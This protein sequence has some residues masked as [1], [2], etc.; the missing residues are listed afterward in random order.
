MGRSHKGF[1]RESAHEVPYQVLEM[2]YADKDNPHDL[3]KTSC[4]YIYT[5][6]SINEDQTEIKVN[7]IHDK[8]SLLTFTLMNLWALI[9]MIFAN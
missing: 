5:F 4:G 6:M 8:P 7:G 2:E 9:E 3:V 1:H